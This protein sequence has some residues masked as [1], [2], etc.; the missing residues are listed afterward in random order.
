MAKGESRGNKRK[1]GGRG[2]SHYGPTPRRGPPALFVTCESG[3]EKKCQRE[4]LELIHHYYYGS[5]HTT[6]DAESKGTS[7]DIKKPS[8]ST[9]IEE[10][11]KPLSLQDELAMLRKGAVAE[12]V[13]NSKRPRHGSTNGIATSK[14]VSTM[15]SPFSIYD[16][17]MRGMVCILCTLPNCEMVPYDKILA[18]LKAAKEK[19]NAT[20]TNNVNGNEKS[21]VKQTTEASKETKVNEVKWDPVHTVRCILRDAKIINKKSDEKDNDSK[22]KDI[23]QAEDD[24]KEAAALLA[25]SPPPGSR[26]ISRILPMQA[27]VSECICFPQILCNMYTWTNI[28]IMF[29]VLH[30]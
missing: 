22:Q 12:E 1:F 16:S 29:S 27:T 20:V 30:Q 23:C 25:S 11:D 24:Q 18:E 28:I 19:D 26:Y 6:T 10:D 14:Q 5:K 2:S 8:P 7:E 9:K 13:L 17:G 21:S 15:K 4:A 3:R